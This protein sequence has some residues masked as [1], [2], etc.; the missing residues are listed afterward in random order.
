MRIHNLSH[1]QINNIP[2]KILDLKGTPRIEQNNLLDTFITITSAKPELEGTSFLSTLDMDPPTTQLSS[3]ASP[4]GSRVHLP[5]MMAGA[6]S[7]STSDSL[8]GGIAS[9]PLSG[10]PTGAEG[11]TRLGESNQRRPGEVFQD[12]RRLLSFGLRRDTTPS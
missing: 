8:F 12:V 10:P 5:S 1:C 9:P 3:L 7:T 4:T 2:S 6:N 11:P